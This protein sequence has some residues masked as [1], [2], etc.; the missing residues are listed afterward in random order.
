M[1]KNIISVLMISMLLLAMVPFTMAKKPE[2]LTASITPTIMIGEN[3]EDTN[4]LGSEN[5]ATN[6][7]ESAAD[8]GDRTIE[9]S[10]ST[11]NGEDKRI[12]T[13]NIMNGKR[14]VSAV[15]ALNTTMKLVERF[16]GRDENLADAIENLPI[17]ISAILAQLPRAEQNK[18]LKMEKE[19]IMERLSKY[20]L[21]IIKK[22]M[23][24]AKR[25]IFA[26]KVA[27]ARTKAVE[28]RDNY[29]EMK[30]ELEQKKAELE[31]TISEKQQSKTIENARRYLQN[32]ADVMIRSL[33]RVEYNV[34]ASDDI[35]ESD[36]ERIIGEIDAHI[37][38]ITDTKTLIQ[39][40]KTDLE[41]QNAK[42]A[43]LAAIKEAK[44]LL[45]DGSQ[46]LVDS[47]LSEIVKRDE[48]L[49]AKLECTLAAIKANGTDVSAMD[50]KLEEFSAKVLEAKEQIKAGETS[51]A[52]KSLNEA[53]EMLKQIVKIIKEADGE[54]IECPLLT[55]VSEGEV[56]VAEEQE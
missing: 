20:N 12:T 2:P 42:K 22:E 39:S 53:H 34:E 41:L 49:E 27:E 23:L 14:I 31:K 4:D 3:D 38:N 15:L 37:Q 19:Q 50:A 25:A 35:S 24:F 29:L 8:E 16:R 17:N 1:R 48:V 52:S 26:E 46:L 40:A 10:G 13:A 43:L 11:E 6:D 5:D 32:A 44:P 9:S 51:K 21:I 28:A 56:L 18:L 45:K 30:Q 7:E 54:I 55:G 47:K 33:E 36:A